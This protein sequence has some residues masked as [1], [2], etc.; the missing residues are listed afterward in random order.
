MPSAIQPTAN[1]L[2]GNVALQCGVSILD[3]EDVWPCSPLQAAL[4]AMD[5]KAPEAYN[6]QYSFAIVE[7]INLKRL[8]HARGQLKN[9]KSIL[10]NRIAYYH[11]TFSFLQETVI[12]HKFETDQ[13]DFDA[14]MYF[15]PGP[16]Q[17]RLRVVCFQPEVNLQPQD[18][19]LHR[20]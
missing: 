1:R 3:I 10:R 11:P 14:P 8:E 18:P 13:N 12:R 7:A 6:Y 19:P 9:A 16:L 15:E 5:L 4:M 17:S 2:K 20:Q